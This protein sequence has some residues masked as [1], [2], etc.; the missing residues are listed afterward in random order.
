VLH[1]EYSSEHSSEPGQ[2]PKKPANW[3]GCVPAIVDRLSMG[4]PKRVSGHLAGTFPPRVIQ[5]KGGPTQNIVQS[6]LSAY[7]Q[8]LQADYAHFNSDMSWRPPSTRYSFSDSDQIFTPASIDTFSPVSSRATL[9]PG[10]PTSTASLD[11]H[12][13]LSPDVQSHTSSVSVLPHRQ[14]LQRS[15]YVTEAALPSTSSPYSHAL[16]PDHAMTGKAG[17]QLAWLAC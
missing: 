9:A 12:R 16:A 10:T 1:T 7:N 11:Y 4:R 3:L 6:P 17:H 8:P 2:S 13:Q 15:E 5:S 14:K